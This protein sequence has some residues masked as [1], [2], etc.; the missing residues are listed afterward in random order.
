M[1]E[2]FAVDKNG[3][4]KHWT[5]EVLESTII[6]RHGKFG[7]KMQSKETTVKGKNIGKA[8][9]TSP[10]EQ[11]LREAEAKYAKQLDKCYRPTI[12]EARN[13]GEALPMLAHNYLQQ[14]HRIIFPCDVSPKLDGVRCIASIVDDEVTLHSRGGKTYDC[15]EHIRRELILVAKKAHVEKLDGELYIHGLPLQDI[16]SAV[17]KPNMNTHRLEFHVFDIPVQRVPWTER[18]N[19]LEAVKQAC[20]LPLKV[21]QNVTVNSEDS[22]RIFLTKFM[23]EGYEGLMLRNLRG[24]YEFNH[25][26]HNL[27]KWKLMNDAEAFVEDVEEDLNGEG[28]LK[29]HMKGDVNKKFKCK[30][31]GSHDERLAAEQRKLIGKWITY[32]YQALTNDGLP[33]FPVGLYVRE[34]DKEGNPIE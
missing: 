23:N 3:G 9:E 17:K 4:V 1:K 25:R 13:V 8:N 20:R 30:M 29:L 27:Q 26:S 14:S 33:Q 34:C 11:A 16:V 12:E 21:V 5:I 19:M 28:V 7:G 2:L 15:P 22:A 10:H 31:K 32:K 18:K 24:V 6:V